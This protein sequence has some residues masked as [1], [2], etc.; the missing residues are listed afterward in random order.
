MSKEIPSFVY[1]VFW[2]STSVAMI[3][4]NKAVLS[5]WGFPYPMF[6]TAWH[7]IFSTILTQIL[8]RITLLLPSVNEGKVTFSIMYRKIMPVSIFFAISL[9]LSNSAYMYLSVSY[10]QMLKAFTPVIILLLS[11]LIG[12]E[13]PSWTQ[14][15][16]VFII[17]VGVAITSVGELNFTLIGFIVQALGIVAEASRL[18]AMDVCVKDLR[19]DSLSVLYYV[20]PLSAILISASCLSLEWNEDLVAKVTGSP[21]LLMCLL[22]SAGIAFM[23][24]IA[25]VL[26]IKH[27][28]AIVLTLVGICKDVM[29]MGLSVLTFGAP[30]TGIQV[31]GYLVALVGINAFK[32]YKKDPNMTSYKEMMSVVL[33]FRN[34]AAKLPL[35]SIPDFQSDAESNVISKT[36][37]LA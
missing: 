23:L 10:I 4:F 5:K 30:V 1:I 9:V 8:S 18:V 2:M 25:S 15:F 33:S 21:S 35:S 6:L 29:L 36:P 32:E 24:N 11:F 17:S 31:F 3:L 19:L 14:L 26:L 37:L 7:C 22:L 28:S 34:K 20:A 27:T 16:I 12:I 13:A